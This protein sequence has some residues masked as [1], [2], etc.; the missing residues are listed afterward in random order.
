MT[1][2]ETDN[3]D[4]MIETPGA[5]R[6]ASASFHSDDGIGGKKKSKKNSKLK[7][8]NQPACCGAEGGGCIL[9]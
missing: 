5:L 1:S 2:A 6:Y 7:L 8:G 3:Y 4:T 9:F